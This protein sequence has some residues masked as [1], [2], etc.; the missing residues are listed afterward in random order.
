MCAV[1]GIN[2]DSLL[3]YM[4][5]ADQ[6][7]VPPVPAWLAR[8]MPDPAFQVQFLKKDNSP[9]WVSNVGPQTWTLLCPFDEILIGGRR[10]GSK[11]SALIAWFAMGDPSLAADDPARYS[12]LNEPSFRGLIL[13]KEYQSMSEFVD[14]CRDFFRPFG[15]KAKDD[16]TVFEFA[17]GAKIYTNHLGDR[18]AYEKYRGHG[19]TKI[20][21]EE[22]TQIPKEEWYLK[23]FGSLRNKKQIRAHTVKDAHGKAVQKTFRRCAARCSRPPIR[24]ARASCGSKTA[25]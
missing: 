16:P 3:P 22:L 18:E 15:G 19:L 23:L 8:A 11:T 14:E 2:F 24:T 5:A 6:Y 9:H 1:R 7:P 10:G 12:C 25:S 20:A 13:R 4:T 21:V 17:S